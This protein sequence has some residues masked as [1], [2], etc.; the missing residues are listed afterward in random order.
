MMVQNWRFGVIIRVVKSGNFA[1]EVITVVKN[2]VVLGGYYKMI[3]KTQ[4][5]LFIRVG[6]KGQFWMAITVV[7]KRQ[8]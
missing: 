7:K 2:G 8:F 6:K 1:W 4:F 3:K 5:C